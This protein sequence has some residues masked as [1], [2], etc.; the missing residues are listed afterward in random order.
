MEIIVENMAGLVIYKTTEE[1]V[2]TLQGLYKKV[3]ENSSLTDQYCL[4]YIK[5]KKTSINNKSH[6][7]LVFNIIH[8]GNNTDIESAENLVYAEPTEQMLGDIQDIEF[9]QDI[10]LPPIKKLDNLSIKIK[11]ELEGLKTTTKQFYANIFVSIGLT[12]ATYFIIT[13]AKHWADKKHLESLKINSLAKTCQHSLK[14]TDF[15]KR[16]YN[17]DENPKI[18]TQKQFDDWKK[19]MALVNSKNPERICGLT[20]FYRFNKHCA[21]NDLHQWC[22]DR[23]DANPSIL[24]TDTQ[25]NDCKRRWKASK[26]RFHNELRQAGWVSF[27]IITTTLSTL[28][29]LASGFFLTEKNYLLYKKIKKDTNN[30]ALCFCRNKNNPSR[31][32]NKPAP[33]TQ[34]LG[35]PLIIEINNTAAHV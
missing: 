25:Y 5:T 22:Y 11:E 27:A 10:P 20:D 8:I 24:V 1:K 34:R 6:D 28:Y 21:Q 18:G 17:K 30:C 16:E 19:C 15:S 32:N 2:K 13:Q 14:D 35:V 26:N 7:S 33:I 9:P 12:I 23:G 4:A 3:Q 29:L 31:T